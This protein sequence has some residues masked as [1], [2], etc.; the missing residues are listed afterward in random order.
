MQIRAAH[1]QPVYSSE[2][3]PAGWRE[4]QKVNYLQKG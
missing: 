1:I 4:A 2:G 3:C